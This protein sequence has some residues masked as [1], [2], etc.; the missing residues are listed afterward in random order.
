[1]MKKNL[2]VGCTLLGVVALFFVGKR[3]GE[4]LT[5]APCDIGEKVETPVHFFTD[6][7]MSESKIQ[8]MIGYSNLVLQ[9]SCV[10][11]Q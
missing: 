5:L 7:S 8:K 6:A 9:N 1:M 4:K 10:P 11:M 2:V 3:S